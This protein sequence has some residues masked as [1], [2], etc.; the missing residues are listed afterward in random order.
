LGRRCRWAPRRAALGPGRRRNEERLRLLPRRSGGGGGLM[1]PAQTRRHALIVGGTGMLYG[2]SLG[3]AERG[4]HVSVVA[5]NR[6]RLYRLAQAVRGLAGTVHPVPVDY[7][8]TD[9]MVAALA[10]TRVRFGPIEL[11]VVWIHGTAPQAPMEVAKMVGDVGAPGR[12]FYVLGSASAN[13]A[14]INGSLRAALA[15]LDNLLYREIILGFVVEGGRSRWLTN[16]EI[17]AGVLHAIDAD[18]P[19][20]VVGTVEPWALHP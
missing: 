20:Y 14:H 18:E 12:Y 15:R 3:L 7:R 10:E 6:D 19:R 1:P 2:A 8:D 4:F 9:R 11:A 17:S 16:A 5:R 13:P